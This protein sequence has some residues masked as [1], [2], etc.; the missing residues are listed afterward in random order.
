M[1]NGSKH[2]FTLIGTATGDQMHRILRRL[3]LRMR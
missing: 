1:N 2:V 3:N